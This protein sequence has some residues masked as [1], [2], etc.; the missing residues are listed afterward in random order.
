MLT[1]WAGIEIM[2]EELVA[3]HLGYIV[4]QIDKFHKEI[5]DLRKKTYESK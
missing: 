3:Y 1:N 5:L 4:E 2:D